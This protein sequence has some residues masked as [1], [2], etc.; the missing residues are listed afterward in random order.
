MYRSS[1]Y[2]TIR[3]NCPSP[4]CGL[5]LQP[6]RPH[7]QP[8]DDVRQSNPCIA[9]T[10]EPEETPEVADDSVKGAANQPL[11]RSMCIRCGWLDVVPCQDGWICH[12]VLCLHRA[13]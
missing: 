1:S 13:L 10:D 5:P 2:N 3:L 7:T 12:L 9:G 8:N 11:E 4:A 6:P